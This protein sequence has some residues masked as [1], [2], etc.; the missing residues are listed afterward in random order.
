MG[1]QAGAAGGF[2]KTSKL[3]ASEL[4]MFETLHTMD[5]KQ[6]QLIEEA[7]RSQVENP[8]WNQQQI[9]TI[10]KH[11]SWRKQLWMHSDGHHP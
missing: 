1:G 8:L 2:I 6:G 3:T 4:L 11:G 5:L 7:Q 9:L 10:P